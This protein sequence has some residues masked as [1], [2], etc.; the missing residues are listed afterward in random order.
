ML[1][2]G[3][4]T[5]HVP[6]MQSKLNPKLKIV[7]AQWPAEWHSYKNTRIAIVGEAPGEDEALTGRPFQGK[8][9]RM[10][11]E[12]LGV[13][14]VPRDGCLVTNVFTERPPNN[15]VAF[16]FQKK[17]VIKEEWAHELKR[18]EVELI[19]FDPHVV[20]CFGATALWAL[21]GIEGITKNRGTVLMSTLGELR[22]KVISMFHPTYVMLGNWGK[23]P[24]VG[25]D[26]LKAKIEA[27]SPDIIRPKREVWINP[28][29]ANLEEFGREYMVGVER[30]CCDIETDPWKCK[31]VLCVGFAPDASHAIV[32]PL[33]DRGRPNWSYWRTAEAEAQA[34]EWIAQWLEDPSITKVGQNF[35][36][37]I[38]YLDR[39]MVIKVRGPIE[40]TMLLHH[41][42]QPEMEK[43]LGYLSSLYTNEQ[44]FKTMVSF[45]TNQ[46]NA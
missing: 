41:A 23:R 8:S 7:E 29:L 4:V 19:L 14:G 18:L 38:Q 5:H 42:L 46:L 15:S 45:K 36:Y 12:L 22:C 39:K 17:G 27:L 10:V 9:G 26:I 34:W 32:V 37:D 11:D 25:S 2:F 33:V 31:Q 21:T 43:G 28:S 20:L 1:L 40:D 6:L 16:F 35:L 13:A 24:V 3:R 44:A 30:I